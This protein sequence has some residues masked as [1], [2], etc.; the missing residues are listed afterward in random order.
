MSD[1]SHHRNSSTPANG[2][3]EHSPSSDPQPTSANSQVNDDCSQVNDHW[4]ARLKGEPD[5]RDQAL[6][7]LREMLLRGLSKPMSSRYGGALSAEDVVQEALVKIL[8]SL[9]QFAG[10]SR[11]TTWAMT[12]AN[13]IGISAMRRKHFQDV[14]IES[15]RTDESAIELASE[16][17]VTLSAEFDRQS[18]V[19][20]LQA[21]IDST[22]SEKQRFAIRATLAGMP[23][24]VIAEK[25]GS[26]RNSVYKMVHDAK[27][28]LKSGLETA[29]I[30]ADALAATFA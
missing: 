12:I 27:S 29:G 26:N 13:R 18:M 23:V 21:L 19:Y 8:E 20:K 3:G 6:S 11:F 4:V 7:E 24:E 5:Q 10:R 30:S 9:D 22:L 15:F 25:S 14:S 17:D 2:S 1:P 16:G 28:K